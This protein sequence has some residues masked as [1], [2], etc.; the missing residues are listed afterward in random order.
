MLQPARHISDEIWR[1]LPNSAKFIMS[2]AGSSKYIVK[3]KIRVNSQNSYCEVCKPCPGGKRGDPERKRQRL[4]CKLAEGVFLTPTRSTG[5]PVSLYAMA[6]RGIPYDGHT[7]KTVLIDMERTVGLRIDRFLADVGYNLSL[8][9][10]RQKVL[11]CLIAIGRQCLSRP[12]TVRNQDDSR[13][14]DFC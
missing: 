14:I 9:I 11:R 8:L 6:L 2:I 13:S 4:V 5:W 12:T 10:R 3:R 1:L 7:L